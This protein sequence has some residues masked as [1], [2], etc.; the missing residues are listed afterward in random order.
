MNRKWVFQRYNETLDWKKDHIN[1][2]LKKSYFKAELI[3]LL[4]YRQ[5]DTLSISCFWFH[6]FFYFTLSRNQIWFDFWYKF[7]TLK[8]S[9]NLYENWKTGVAK[10]VLKILGSFA[11]FHNSGVLK[12]QN[13][14]KPKLYSPKA[15]S[16]TKKLF[17]SVPEQA[18]CQFH[19]RFTCTFFCAK[20]HSNPNSKQRKA[21]LNTDTTWT[22]ISKKIVTGTVR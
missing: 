11:I 7:F 3:N 12:N 18:R 14:P 5:C 20:V 9:Q 6:N 19:Q 17:I 16:K 4:V 8:I 2:E 15:H 21:W 10:K 1:K 13:W 22:K